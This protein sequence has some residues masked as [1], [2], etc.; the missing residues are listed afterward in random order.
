M[1][2][3]RMAE[4]LKDNDVVCRTLSHTYKSGK[5][6]TFKICQSHQQNVIELNG[7]MKFTYFSK[8]SWPSFLSDSVFRSPRGSTSTP[9]SC[10]CG[11]NQLQSS[12]ISKLLKSN[13]TKLILWLYTLKNQTK[14]KYFG[15]YFSIGKPNWTYRILHIM[16]KTLSVL[17]CNWGFRI[18]S[19]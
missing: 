9:A 4:Q 13:Q 18:S 8:T 16:F 10:K 14:Q 6:K 12:I 11:S 15:L 3:Y 2:L 17:Y 5:Q 7:E 19:F 1:A